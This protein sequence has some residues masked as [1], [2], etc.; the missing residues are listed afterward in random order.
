MESKSILRSKYLDIELY[1]S[2]I[3]GVVYNMEDEVQVI[4]LPFIILKIKVG[5]MFR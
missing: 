5:K 4:I 1:A 2:V 3:I